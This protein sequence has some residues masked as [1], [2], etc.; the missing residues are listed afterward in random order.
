MECFK[1]FLDRPT[2]NL[3]DLNLIIPAILEKSDV[4]S[5]A[6]LLNALIKA[7][8][9][10]QDDFKYLVGSEFIPTDQVILFIS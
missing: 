3:N 1:R 10:Q 4:K 7:D 6:K 5:A 8:L 9:V 2:A